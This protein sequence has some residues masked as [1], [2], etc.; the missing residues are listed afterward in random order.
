MQG[1]E[2]IT[3]PPFL[4]NYIEHNQ[5]KT[6]APCFFLFTFKNVFLIFALSSFLT[7]LNL[8][9]QSLFVLV[10]YSDRIPICLDLD[11]EM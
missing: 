2:C 4:G 11:V 10:I 1:L 7:V 9:M 6:P 3:P 8:Q 5:Q